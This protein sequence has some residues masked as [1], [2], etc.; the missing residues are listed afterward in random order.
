MLYENEIVYRPPL[1]AES[2]LLEVAVGCSYGKCTFCKSSA[3][4]TAPFHIIPLETVEKNA[5][6]LGSTP[7]EQGREGCFLLGENVLALPMDHLKAVIGFVNKWLPDVKRFAM[8]ARAHDVIHKGWEGL[9]ELKELGLENIYMG[10]ESGSDRILTEC[11]KGET[12]ADLRLACELLDSLEIAYHLSSILGLG[13]RELWKEHAVAT[14]QFFNSVRPAS[15]RVLTYTPEEGTV[16]AAQAESGAFH[17]V[18]PAQA[19]LEEYVFLYALKP[20]NRYLFVGTHVTNNVSLAGF[21]P[22]HQ[23]TLLAKL[24]EALQAPGLDSLEAARPEYL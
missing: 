18:T 10:V 6:T 8:Y 4:D 5:R 19:L 17:M 14:A 11:R 22:D 20:S 21:L 12:S 1:E 15:V 2:V 16:M 23:Q 24:K 9:L 3:A 13:G 7:S